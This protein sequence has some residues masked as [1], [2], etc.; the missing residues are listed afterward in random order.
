MNSEQSTVIAL[1]SLN[2][3]IAND[4]LR[5]VVPGSSGL[6]PEDLRARAA[7]PELLGS[8]LDFLM[9]ND[10]WVMSCCD[11]LGHPYEALQQARAALPGGQQ[12]H[13]T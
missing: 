4:D 8:V 7:E 13:W 6:S 2:W 12:M 5:D 1:G 3:L 10:A 11:A 9:M